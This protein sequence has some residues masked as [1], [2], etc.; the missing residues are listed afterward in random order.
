MVPDLIWG[1]DNAGSNSV[2]PTILI[3]DCGLVQGFVRESHNLQ[4]DGFKSLTRYQILRMES[5][6]VPMRIQQTP[7]I[8]VSTINRGDDG[9]MN[10]STRCSDGGA[11]TRQLPLVAVGRMPD[12][13]QG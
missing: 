4:I 3:F 8:G 5:N 12:A 9:S 11:A 13:R 10:T 6:L 7:V 1:E 2:T